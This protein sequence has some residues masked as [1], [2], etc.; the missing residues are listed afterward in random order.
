MWDSDEQRGI[1]LNDYG[2]WNGDD[3]Y[4]YVESITQAHATGTTYTLPSSYKAGYSF[5]G[6]RSALDNTLYSAGTEI[7]VNQSKTYT[8]E[9]EILSLTIDDKTYRMD[10]AHGNSSIGWI[11]EPDGEYGYYN[12]NVELQIFGN[13]SGKPIDVQSDVNIRI[14]GNITGS[15]GRSA[16]SV[17]GNAS[18]C[19][20]YYNNDNNKEKT[21]FISGGNNAP[22]IEVAGTLVLS[23]GRGKLAVEGGSAQPALH[24]A[25]VVNDVAF[26]QVLPR[27]MQLTSQTTRM[28]VIFASVIQLQL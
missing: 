18:I 8:A 24:A 13:Y 20:A 2:Y 26:W 28:K 23:G 7:T 9:Y 16:I 6:W 5:N 3:Q 10:K 21:A 14:G 22:A 15:D 11:F 27:L 25:K 17:D 19:A 1:T 12:G 4:Y